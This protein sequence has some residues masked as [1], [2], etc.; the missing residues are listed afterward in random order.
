MNNF[1]LAGLMAGTASPLS[2]S[3]AGGDGPD[4]FS[5]LIRVLSILFLILALLFISFYLTRGPL[6]KLKKRIGLKGGEE[7]IK[8]IDIRHIAPKKSIGV[9]DV[10]GHIIVVGITANDI[11]LLARLDTPSPRG[12]DI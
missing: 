6:K 8:V 1:M 7:I 9:V 2:A 11:N 10:A 5:S 4:L 12:I 3:P